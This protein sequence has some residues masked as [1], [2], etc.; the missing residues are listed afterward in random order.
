MVKVKMYMVTYIHIY[1]HINKCIILLGLIAL[2]IKQT[3]YFYTFLGSPLTWNFQSLKSKLQ[4]K[5]Q[6]VHFATPVKEEFWGYDI[7]SRS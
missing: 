2:W 7:K 1:I 3:T 4:A 6:T 5:M